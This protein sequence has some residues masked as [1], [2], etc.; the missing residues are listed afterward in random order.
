M[1]LSIIKG[2]IFKIVKPLYNISKAGNY[3]FKTYY[4]YYLNK[5]D[6]SQSIYDLCLFYRNKPFKVVGLQTDDTLFIGDAEF[7]DKKQNNLKKA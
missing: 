7:A 1:Q 2:S 5:L 4:I 3:W 6:I